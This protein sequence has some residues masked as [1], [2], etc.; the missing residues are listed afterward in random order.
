M[1]LTMMRYVILGFIVCERIRYPRLC[2]TYK[3]FN[4][5]QYGLTFLGVDW[6]I[7]MCFLLLSS[8]RRLQWWVWCMSLYYCDTEK[9]EIISPSD[10]PTAGCAASREVLCNCVWVTYLKVTFKY[11]LAPFRTPHPVSPLCIYAWMTIHPSIKPHHLY[12]TTI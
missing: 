6:P 3:L 8:P 1:C 12:L 4:H 5:Y 11:S 2:H 9:M 7:L 10:Y